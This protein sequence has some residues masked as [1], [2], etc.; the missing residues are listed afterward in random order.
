MPKS[1]LCPARLYLICVWLPVSPYP[2]PAHSTPLCQP[3]A[4]PQALRAHF[5]FRAFDAV[6][7][8]AFPPNTLPQVSARL[9]PSLP[10]NLCWTSLSHS[11]PMKCCHLLLTP[12]QYFQSLP[13][14]SW[15]FVF[16]FFFYTA[17]IS[18]E[19]T[20]YFPCGLCLL[21]IGY[22]SLLK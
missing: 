3:H 5:H 7:S 16:L 9:S 15:F 21:F 17:L 22:L 11:L 8:S 18:F 13:L 2:H 19:H 6:L 14:L 1:F 12:P 10:S 20:I 4:V